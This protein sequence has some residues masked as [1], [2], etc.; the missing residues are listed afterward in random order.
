M[1]QRVSNLVCGVATWLPLVNVVLLFNLQ[2]LYYAD[3]REAE[4]TRDAVQAREE[5]MRMQREAD[6]FG[7]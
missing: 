1:N 5:M 2:K 3:R 7:K 4:L 6:P